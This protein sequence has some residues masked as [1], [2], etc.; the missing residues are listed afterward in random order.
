MAGVS[1]LNAAR[2]QVCLTEYGGGESPSR[3]ESANSGRHPIRNSPVQQ[4]V[5]RSFGRYSFGAVTVG[6]IMVI[7]VGRVGRYGGLG[8][9]GP[10]GP[11]AVDRRTSAGRRANPTLRRK[12]R[13]LSFK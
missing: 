10:G 12:S 13:L 8:V 3:A 7:H 5:V 2:E 9:W 1:K 4:R 11:G 6:D